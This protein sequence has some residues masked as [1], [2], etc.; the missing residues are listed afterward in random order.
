MS[1]KET[2]PKLAS[3]AGATLA[4]PQAS[5]IQRTLAA[6]ALS[7]AGGG[8]PSAETLHRA[9]QALNNDRSADVTRSLAA[10]VLAQAPSTGSQG[11]KA[12]KG[13]R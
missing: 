13:R 7:G 4:N 12:G 1:D 8:T 9:S 10:S 5:G 11:A 3:E 2:S 6:A